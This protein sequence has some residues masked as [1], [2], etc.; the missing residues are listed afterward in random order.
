ME[1][2]TK[3]LYHNYFVFIPIASLMIFFDIKETLRLLRLHPCYRLFSLIP[4][5]ALLYPLTKTA[6][7]GM[8]GP[9]WFR[10]YFAD[11][12]FIPFFTYA[13]ILKEFMGNLN[14][15]RIRAVAW[16]AGIFAIAAEFFQIFMLKKGYLSLSGLKNLT[17]RGDLVDMW[18]FFIMLVVV[19]VI[20]NITE[21]RT[22]TAWQIKYNSLNGNEKRRYRDKKAK[23]LR[24]LKIKV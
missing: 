13:A 9:T 21:K 22:R 5:L 8:I 4:L 20:T 12:G 18:I 1:Q 23:I 10:S 3:F 19:L 2:V 11:I 7:F 16:I 17:A 15:R 14:F 6:Q 24:N